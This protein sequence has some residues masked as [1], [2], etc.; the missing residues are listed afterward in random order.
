MQVGGFDLLSFHSSLEIEPESRKI[1]ITPIH[2]NWRQSFEL[3]SATLFVAL[4]G[5]RNNSGIPRVHSWSVWARSGRFRDLE[6]VFVVESVH[7]EYTVCA[8]VKRRP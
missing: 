8:K 1:P 3:R 7:G 2:S 4:F 5:A 6:V